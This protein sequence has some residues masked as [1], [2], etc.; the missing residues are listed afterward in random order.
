MEPGWCPIQYPIVIGISLRVKWNVYWVNDQE[1]KG[2]FHHMERDPLV[3]YQQVSEREWA[4][5]SK[6]KLLNLVITLINVSANELPEAHLSCSE[7]ASYLN[8][9]WTEI[10]TEAKIAP[11]RT[12]NAERAK[13]IVRT[14]SVTGKDTLSGSHVKSTTCF[15]TWHFKTPASQ[16]NDQ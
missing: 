8:G 4:A 7:R 2:G 11:T 1:F 5:N 13:I 3:I 6:Q 12:A 14:N 9:N 10:S 15:W 16:Y